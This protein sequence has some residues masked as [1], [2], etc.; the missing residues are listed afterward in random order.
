MQD[1][2]A[3]D[4]YDVEFINGG[5]QDR[6]DVGKEGNQKWRTQERRN[7]GKEEYIK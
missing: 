4:R 7:A 6:R 2:R 1:R 3:Q 5:L